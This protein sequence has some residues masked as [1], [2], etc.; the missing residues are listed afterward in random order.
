MFT[1]QNDFECVLEIN[2]KTDIRNKENKMDNRV[3]RLFKLKEL[4]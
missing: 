2:T 4:T 1:Y 3:E